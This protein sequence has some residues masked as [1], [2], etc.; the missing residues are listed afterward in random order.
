MRKKL[1]WENVVSIEDKENLE[2]KKYYC[3]SLFDFIFL[4]KFMWELKFVFR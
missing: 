1:E 3:I 4:T 2:F